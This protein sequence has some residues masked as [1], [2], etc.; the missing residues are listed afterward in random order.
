MRSQQE[1]NKARC[2]QILNQSWTKIRPYIEEYEGI[3]ERGGPQNEREHIIN[4]IFANVAYQ[5]LVFTN[6]DEN[7]LVEDIVGSS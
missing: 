7:Y 4:D 1:V 5:H 2:D 3:A 6:A